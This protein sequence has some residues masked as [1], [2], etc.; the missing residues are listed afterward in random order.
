MKP[1]EAELWGVSLSFST[2]NKHMKLLL[3]LKIQGVVVYNDNETCLTQIQGVMNGTN[4]FFRC[5][6]LN[7]IAYTFIEM[8]HK[9]IDLKITKIKAHKGN[10]CG[11]FFC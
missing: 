7:N 8:T 10:T 5:N 9:Q 2:I 11:S 6:A 1:Y 3:Q 4:N